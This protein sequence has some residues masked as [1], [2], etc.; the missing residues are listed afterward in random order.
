MYLQ[1]IWEICENEMIKIVY[2][3]YECV[4]VVAQRERERAEE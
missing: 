3:I 4:F 1:D 2:F